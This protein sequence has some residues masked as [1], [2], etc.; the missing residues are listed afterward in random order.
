[1]FYEIGTDHGLPYDPFKV[2]EFSYLYQSRNPSMFSSRCKSTFEF[3]LFTEKY[4]ASHVSLRK[5]IYLGQRSRRLHISAL[6]AREIDM[7]R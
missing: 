4:T 5:W 2:S 3:E 1:M 7:C 6:T